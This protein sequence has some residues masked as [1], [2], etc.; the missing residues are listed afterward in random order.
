MVKKFAHEMSSEIKYLLPE[1]EASKK[2]NI[3]KFP[4]L[5][6]DNGANN[7]GRITTG[8]SLQANHGG[9]ILTGES[10][11]SSVVSIGNC[12]LDA[13]CEKRD[14]VARGARFSR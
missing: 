9:R 10:G 11:S 4:S 1:I 13:E 6:S 8:E 3:C 7:D 12:V 14:R 5:F 2:N